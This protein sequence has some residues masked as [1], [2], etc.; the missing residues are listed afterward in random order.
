MTKRRSETGEEIPSGT[1]TG[2]IEPATVSRET[3]LESVPYGM[4]SAMPQG[5]DV[6]I[7]AAGAAEPSAFEPGT[8]KG[9]PQWRCRRCAWDTLAGEEAILAHILEVHEPP[10]RPPSPPLVAVS[11]RWGREVRPLQGAQH[12]PAQAP[13][14]EGGQEE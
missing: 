6:D 1:R 12:E 4:Q 9:F 8:W 3:T 7:E 2:A 10:L 13:P 11:D 14:S 5:H